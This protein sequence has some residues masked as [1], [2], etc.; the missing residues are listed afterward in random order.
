MTDKLA[1]KSFRIQQFKAIQDSQEIN[2]GPLTAFIGYNGSGK[3]SLIEA[4]E[5]L[6][7]IVATDLD[8]AMQRWRGFE[9]IWNRQGQHQQRLLSTKTIARPH[10]TNPLNFQLQGFGPDSIPYRASMSINSDPSGNEIFIQEEKVTLKNR[11]IM[12]RDAQGRVSLFYPK[13][14]AA[15]VADGESSLPYEL[16][17]F[18]NR[19]QFLSLSPNTMGQPTTRR[20]TGGIIGLNKDGSNIA[21]YLLD[22]QKTDE[23]QN[24]TAFKA[25]LETLQ[26][27]LDY[28]QDLQ[29]TVTSELERMVYLQMTEGEAKVPGWLL[30]SGTLR[31][32]AV[33]AT[34]R[35]PQPPPLIVIEEIENGFDPRTVELIANEVKK[36]VADG[37]SQVVITTHSPHFLDLLELPDIVLVGRGKQGTTFQPPSDNETLKRWAKEYGLGRLYTTNALH[38]FALEG[39]ESETVK[40]VELRLRDLIDGRLTTVFG[41]HYWKQR[42]P[43]DTKNTVKSRT[44]TYFEKYPYVSRDIFSFPRTKLDY[45][46]VVDYEKIIFYS[47]EEAF[48]DIFGRRDSFTQHL[49][50]FREFRNSVAHNYEIN[51]VQK[52][53]A[54]AAIL[55]LEQILNV[56]N[57]A[58]EGNALVEDD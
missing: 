49:T 39:K 51:D 9:H 22:I 10:H 34:L 45:C 40:G 1:L 52:K 13:V 58:S 14:D 6:Q 50:N 2:F 26:Y 16:K 30:S 56:Y 15:Q 19:W 29:P 7:D 4:L 48:K 53:S 27:I 5:T 37:K 42:I 41:K 38:S 20:R 31:L 11:K 55:W 33:L 25:I 32:V 28:T 18:I 21:E 23:R 57:T 12:K 36:V 54:E 24:T 17:L 46:D 43:G 44:D 35:H 47:W 8:T 3:S